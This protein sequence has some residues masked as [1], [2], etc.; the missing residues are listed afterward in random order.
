MKIKPRDQNATLLSTALPKARNN[1]Q[2]KCVSTFFIS[3][4]FQF[5]CISKSI[6]KVMR[7]NPDKIT[8]KSKTQA[9]IFQNSIQLYPFQVSCISKDGIKTE[10][11]ANKPKHHANNTDLPASAH[12]KNMFQQ[13]FILT[14]IW[15]H[16]TQADAWNINDKDL[17]PALQEIW[18]TVYHHTITHQIEVNG[19][20]FQVVHCNL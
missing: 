12:D 19:A 2:A 17:V 4:P 13:H 9:V 10:E 20:V 3:Y 15:Y 7:V 6:V 11:V 1:S 8:N 18:D 14:A 16:A 5:S